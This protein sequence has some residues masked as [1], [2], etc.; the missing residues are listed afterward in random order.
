MVPQ[1]TTDTLQTNQVD[2][3]T[4]TKKKQK[5]KN[6]KK[7]KKQNSKPTHEQQKTKVDLHMEVRERLFY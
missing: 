3:V 1:E 2:T 7:A 6:S 4:L 5:K